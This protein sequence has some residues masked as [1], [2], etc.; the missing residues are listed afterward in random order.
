MTNVDV[1]YEDLVDLV[2]KRLSVDEFVDRITMMGSGPE[3][4]QGDVLTFDIFPNRPDLYSVEGIARGLRGFLGLEVGLSTYAASPSGIDFVVDPSVAAVRP[5]GVG[6]VV[7]GVDLEDRLLRSLVDLQEKLH[8]T[9]GRRRRKVAIGIHD[10]DKVRPPFAFRG[11]PPRSL[12][13]VPLGMAEEMDL[14]EIL[15]RHE[16]GREYGPIVADKPVFPIITDRDGTVLSFPPVINGV[17]SQLTPETRNLFIDVTGTDA[18]AVSSALTILCTSLAERGGRIETVRTVVADRILETP[19]LAPRDHTVDLPRANERLGLRVPTLEAVE[20]LRRMRYDARAD[21]DLLHVRAPAYRTDLLHEVD[22]AED[23]A[24]A[25]GYDRY[26]KGLPREQTYGTPTAENEFSDALRVLLIGYGYQEVM[27]LTV[28]A[29]QDDFDTPDRATI[30]NPVGEDLTTLRSSLVP[31]LFGI[32]RLNKH[33][34]LPQRVFEVA[35][36]VIG[37]RN[38]RK[39][40]VAAIHHKASFTEAKSLALSLL[41][42]VGRKGEV[43][44]VE[45]PNFIPGRSAAILVGGKDLGH[46]GEIHPRILEAYALV[47]PAIAL[48][49]DLESILLA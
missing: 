35:D 3:G 19:D 5:H 29:A 37:G 21:G 1:T 44:A 27:S 26:P 45:D 43:E 15:E 8:L 12:R 48:E 47:Q 6:G 23:L 22:I 2:G 18:V 49:I 30:R 32:F 42:D 25:W 17:V 4:V 39:L 40:G 38:V 20:A 34:E 41:R 33:R 10:L 9:L 36:V 7:R 11:V 13:F 28:A 16:K 14:Q 24:I 46:F 31:G